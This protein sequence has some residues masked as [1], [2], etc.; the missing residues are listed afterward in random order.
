MDNDV[1]GEKGNRHCFK[2]DSDNPTHHK[3]SG[4][5]QS[6]TDCSPNIQGVVT[7]ETYLVRVKGPRQ[8]DN[9]DVKLL[10]QKMDD[11][12]S[13]FSCLNFAIYLCWWCCTSVEM[14]ISKVHRGLKCRRVTRD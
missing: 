3:T 9:H 4:P 12:D 1:L 11:S 14:P 2:E 6:I 5:K 8:N 7:L 13:L 10:G